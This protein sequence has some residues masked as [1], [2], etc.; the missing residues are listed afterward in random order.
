MLRR[1]LSNAEVHRSPSRRQGIFQSGAQNTRLDASVIETIAAH[2]L[3]MCTMKCINDVL[4]KSLNYNSKKKRCEKLSGN[5]LTD[6]ESKLIAAYSWEHYEPEDLTVVEA[7]QTKIEPV[8]HIGLHSPK[9]GPFQKCEADL[10]KAEGFR[11]IGKNLESHANL[12]IYIN[13]TTSN[14]IYFSSSKVI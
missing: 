4:C 12:I 2:T 11:C 7:F 9:C 8:C 6:G 3:L 10:S 5:R 1:N 13:L 14:I